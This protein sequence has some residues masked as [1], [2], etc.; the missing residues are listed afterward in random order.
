MYMVDDLQRW[1]RIVVFYV[2]QMLHTNITELQR[3]K[4][5]WIVNNV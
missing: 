5:R 1:H 4:R 3:I 2:Q